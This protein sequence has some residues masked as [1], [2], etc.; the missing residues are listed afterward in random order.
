MSSSV[1]AFARPYVFI[2]SSGVLPAFAV[3]V[4]EGDAI[5]AGFFG[6]A[7]FAGAA[8]A[9]GAGGTGVAV[10]ST[11]AVAMGDGSCASAIGVRAV[12]ART[13][14]VKRGVKE[15]FIV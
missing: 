14:P 10:F 7:G 6:A 3:A 2:M 15:S 5:A 4:A 9:G 8:T 11:V 13:T 12:L 1:A